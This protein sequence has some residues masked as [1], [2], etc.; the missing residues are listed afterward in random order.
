MYVT[1]KKKVQGGI[2]IY[3]EW[4]FDDHFMTSDD[5]LNDRPM[6]VWWFS[7]DCLMTI[8]WPTDGCPPYHIDECLMTL[9]DDCLMT[10]DYCQWLPNDCLMTAWWLPDDCP[11]TFPDDCPMTARWLSNDCPMTAWWLTD[12]WLPNDCLITARWLPDHCLIQGFFKGSSR[13][14]NCCSIWRNETVEPKTQAS[15]K[16]LS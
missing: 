10:G 7:D 8:W 11:M 16:L 6:T 12:W 5:H 15:L 4:P 14:L 9:P 2:S 3:K 13:I 1:F